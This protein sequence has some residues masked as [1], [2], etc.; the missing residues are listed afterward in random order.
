[1]ERDLTQEVAAVIADRS[2]TTSG[3]DARGWRCCFSDERQHVRLETFWKPAVATGGKWIGSLTL[4][5]FPKREASRAA[6]SAHESDELIEDR[7]PQVRR[8]RPRCLREADSREGPPSR[9][10]HQRNDFA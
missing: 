7:H 3:V 8:A 5:L 6:R 10:R 4:P 1:M 2:D 9:R